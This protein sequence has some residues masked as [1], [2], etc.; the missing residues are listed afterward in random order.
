MISLVSSLFLFLFKLEKSSLQVLSGQTVSIRLKSTV[1]IACTVFQSIPLCTIRI[2]L[3]DY[4][5]QFS[6]QQPHC[7]QSLVE[8]IHWSDCGL[9]FDGWRWD[10]WQT[11]NV[12]ALADQSSR[13][14][15]TA[16][17]KLRGISNR[18]TLW[19]YYSVPDIY[20]S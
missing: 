15:Y 6:G 14:S 18:D 11:I 1:P 20:V 4:K 19:K 9:D 12:S 5:G 2:E 8:D 3:F 13:P 16:L 10:S 17:V 7:N